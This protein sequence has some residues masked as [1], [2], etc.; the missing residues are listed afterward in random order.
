MWV[1]PAYLSR[2]V[3]DPYLKQLAIR[4]SCTEIRFERNA[5]ISDNALDAFH[6][7]IRSLGE[8]KFLN[9]HIIALM[10]FGLR[11]RRAE[12]LSR[13]FEPMTRFKS[14]VDHTE[15]IAISDISATRP[16]R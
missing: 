16:H 10:R 1:F 7:I 13:Q 4:H 14:A 11:F 8:T 5:E 3:R 6:Q 2:Q 9:A 15:T 12:R